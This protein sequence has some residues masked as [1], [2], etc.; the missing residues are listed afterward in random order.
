MRMY[1]RSFILAAMAALACAPGALADTETTDL[2]FAADTEG[3]DVCQNFHLGYS[4]GSYSGSCSDAT[5]GGYLGSSEDLVFGAVDGLPLTLDVARPI[6]IDLVTS[7]WLGDSPRGPLGD[8]TISITV[9]GKRQ[10]SNQTVTIGSISKTTPATERINSNEM[11]MSFDIQPAADKAGVYKSLSV[12]V[13]TGGA[14][15]GGYTA[16]DGTSFVSFPII[17]GTAPPIPEDF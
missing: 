2:V 1:G 3:E 16:V 6:H 13:R 10:S 9:T 17:D 14:L 12:A 8:E 4:T 15:L 5:F 7:M 11:A